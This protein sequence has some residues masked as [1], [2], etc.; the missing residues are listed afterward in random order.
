MQNDLGN[1]AGL[2]EEESQKFGEMQT[3]INEKDS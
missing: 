2:Q 1:E 3:R